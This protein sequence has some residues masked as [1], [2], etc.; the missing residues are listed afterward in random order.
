MP[1]WVI[2]KRFK[3]FVDIPGYYA[4][5]Y[6]NLVVSGGINTAAIDNYREGV[7]LRTVQDIY[8]S[9]QVKV[10][11]TDGTQDAEVEMN[12]DLIHQSPF[13]TYG[14]ALDFIQY[15]DNAAFN[16]SH[17]GVD[18]TL[19]GPGNNR[20]PKTAQYLI[21]VGLITEGYLE[22]NNIFPIYMNG[23]PQFYEEA[24]IEPFIIPERLNTNESPQELSRGVFAFL[25][26]GNQGD[27]RRFGTN[28][29]EQRIY[30]DEPAV[31]RPYL[32]YGADYILVTG[33][34]GK[35]ID[36]IH[37]KPSAVPDQ[38][39]NPKIKPWKDEPKGQYFPVLTNTMDLL[40]I[41]VNGELYTDGYEASDFEF[42][43]RD[44]KSS[45]AGFTYGNGLYGTDSIAFGGLLRGGV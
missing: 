40:N 8:S 13:I 3:P 44:Q 21:D 45:C 32:E 25:E 27:E 7:N 1:Y 30:R 9:N 6:R 20:I 24:I 4:K 26:G 33:S 37:I 36:T 35:V 28:M 14:Q 23:G 15:T 5:T 2:D 22:N 17:L 16:D 42:Q 11:V 10:I 38:T 39:F 31:V 18:G 12:G 41:I 29:V 43:T 19:L 34:N